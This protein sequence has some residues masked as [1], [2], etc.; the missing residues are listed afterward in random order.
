M[1]FLKSFS[2]FV[3]DQLIAKGFSIKNRPDTHKLT[4]GLVQRITIEEPTSILWA[5]T[6]LFS[7]N[8][9]EAFIREEAYHSYI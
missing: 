5:S 9:L 7:E 8:L 4:N 1:K 6:I 2:R 3:V